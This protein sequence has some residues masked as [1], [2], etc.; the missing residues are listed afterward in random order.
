MQFLDEVGEICAEYDRVAMATRTA[1]LAQMQR[2][3]VRVSEAVEADRKRQ[4]TEFDERMHE[5]RARYEQDDMRRQMA[6]AER[7]AAEEVDRKRAAVDAERAR[8]D[9]DLE[10]EREWEREREVVQVTIAQFEHRVAQLEQELREARGAQ[11]V[12]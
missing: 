2:A 3:A 4:M 6:A 7:A 5:L 11:G 1:F 8:R 12:S 10:R 9:S